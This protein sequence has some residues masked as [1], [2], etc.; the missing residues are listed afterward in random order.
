MADRSKIEWTDHTWIPIAGCDPISP[1]CAKCYAAL[2]AARLEKMGQSKY[3]GLATR[4]GNLGKWTGEITLSE[5][6]LLKP[7]E[8]KKPARWFLTSMGD[9]FHRKVPFDFLDRLFAVMSLTPQHTY[10]VLTKRPEVAAEYLGPSSE[11][12]GMTRDVLVEGEAQALHH[13][14]TGE[15]PSLWLAVH[16]PLPNVLIGCTA[17]DQQRADERRTYMERIAYSG[18]RTFV[19]YEP[20][21]G[22]VDWTGWA[23][24]SWMISGG[25]SGQG[26]R[27]S[28]PDW[29]RDTRDWC[30]G[31]GIPY[32]FKQWGEWTPGENVERQRGVVQTAALDG[33]D[34]AVEWFFSSE[35]LARC[36]G[37]RDD[38][39]DLYRVGKKASGRH[40]D[41]QIHDAFPEVRHG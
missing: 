33:D 23:F 7:L 32:M 15:D 39:P 5:A 3:T 25:E 30:A 13:Q 17:E 18:W 40:L 10:Y 20:A 12:E 21:L 26:A 2:M 6:D 1:A 14:R 9:V 11:L 35:N 22:P 34:E 19:S 16:W 37:H 38:E 31:A 4:Q 41:G 36:D 24:L 29:H 8:V 27:P 28:H